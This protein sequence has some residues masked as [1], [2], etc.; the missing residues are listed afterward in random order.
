[1][2]GYEFDSLVEDIKAGVVDGSKWNYCYD[3]TD[4]PGYGWQALIMGTGGEQC[5]AS[6][7]EFPSEQA[8]RD[9]Y[10]SLGVKDDEIMG[11]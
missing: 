10:H 6:K 1:M 11:M 3:F 8:I 7:S 9:L 4:L 2:S 5:V